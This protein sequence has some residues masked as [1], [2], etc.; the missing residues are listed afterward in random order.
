LRSA[1]LRVPD[2]PFFKHTRF[3]PLPDQTEKHTITHPAAQKRPELG[4]VERVEKPLHVKLNHPSAPNAHELVSPDLQ[5]LV[6][7]PAGPKPV[8]A[9]QKV[10]L[11]Y[12]LEHHD[13]RP[14]KN[15]VLEGRHSDRASGRAIALREV[16]SLHG[17]RSVAARLGAIEQIP[18]ILFQVLRIRG[19]RLSV[20]AWRA[21]L[22]RAPIGLMEPD[23]VDVVVERREAHLRR[24][25]RTRRYRLLS[26]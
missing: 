20:Y 25:L 19:S 12:R 6:R 8:R 13:H 26:R 16:R 4:F 7:R 23:H 17:W 24:L 21:I 15:L 9:V 10:L 1:S 18:E 5:G 11:V 3:Q 14:L 2:G 22:P